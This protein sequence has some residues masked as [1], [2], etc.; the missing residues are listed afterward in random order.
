LQEK[1]DLVLVGHA[2]AA[3]HL[4]RLVADEMERLA[5]LGLGQAGEGGYVLAPGIEGSE[6][7]RDSRSRELE[8]TEHRRG[9]MLQRLERADGDAELLPLLE[10]LQRALEGCRRR[11]EH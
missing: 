4:H 8:R 1:A 5:G 3:M 7:R 11:A 6:R 10:I 9:A 2:D